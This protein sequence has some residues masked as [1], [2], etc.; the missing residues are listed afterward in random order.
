MIVCCSL[1]LV[2]NRFH[3]LY[4]WQVLTS[5]PSAR[6]VCHLQAFHGHLQHSCQSISLIILA[7]SVVCVLKATAVLAC[8][9]LCFLRAIFN[10]F[11]S[12]SSRQQF[13]SSTLMVKHPDMLYTFSMACAAS[14]QWQQLANVLQR[15]LT[16]KRK[17]CLK[18]TCKITFN[19]VN[20]P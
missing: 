12:S 15:C 6:W 17:Q 1:L 11:L 14:K 5:I 4:A 9:V 2:V 13:C 20:N 19:A 8:N 16:F 18:F 7:C 10:F 3:H